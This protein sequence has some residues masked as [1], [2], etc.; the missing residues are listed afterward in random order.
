MEGVDNARGTST[1]DVAMLNADLGLEHAGS[2]GVYVLGRC[3]CV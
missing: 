1:D 2:A 3:V